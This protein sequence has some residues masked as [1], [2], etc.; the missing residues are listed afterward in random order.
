MPC[1]FHIIYIPVLSIPSLHYLDVYESLLL[2]VIY[3]SQTQNGGRDGAVG[4]ANRN[5]LEVSGFTPGWGK[6]FC[7]RPAGPEAYPAFCIMGN[8]PFSGG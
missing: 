2:I 3:T 1:L 8:G 5:D 7:I 6:I 4:V